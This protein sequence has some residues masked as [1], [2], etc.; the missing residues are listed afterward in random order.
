MGILTGKF[1]NKTIFPDGDLRKDWP[2]ETWFQEDLQTVKKLRLLSNKNQTLGQLALRYVL[3]H[4]A[5]SVVIPGAKSG[6]QAQENAN[7]SVRP[8]LSDEELNYIHSI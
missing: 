8:I 7:A 3:S 2:N 5:V 1:T 6:T 4:P